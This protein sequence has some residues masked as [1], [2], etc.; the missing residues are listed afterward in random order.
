MS[1]LSA[2]GHALGDIAKDVEHGIE[3]ASEGFLCGGPLGALIGGASGAFS[4]FGAQGGWEGLFGGQPNNSAKVPTVEAD[5]PQIRSMMEGGGAE[6]GTTPFGDSSG[7]DAVV[8]G[9]PTIGD[10]NPP[11]VE[12]LEQFLAQL[13]VQDQ[14]QSPPSC[15]AGDQTGGGNQPGGSDQ[16]AEREQDLQQ[17][18]IRKLITEAVSML[19]EEALAA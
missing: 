16:F 15:N 18:N 11:M 17:D 5:I 12:V 14:D 2:I 10:S 7:L 19:S 1:F 13:L 8:P 4:G 3:G 6:L 9:G